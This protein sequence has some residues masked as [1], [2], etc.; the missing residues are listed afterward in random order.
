[1]M[2]QVS[3]SADQAGKSFKDLATQAAAVGSAIGGLAGVMAR[4]GQMHVNE[5]RQIAVINRMYADQADAILDATEAI[6]D[7]S[8]FSNNSARQSAIL[9]NTLTQNYG[10]SID[11]LKSLLTLSADLAT[12]HN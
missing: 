8:I 5:E 12:A 6:Q 1:A 9:L 10:M 4:L 7:Y 2:K 3:S 11:Q